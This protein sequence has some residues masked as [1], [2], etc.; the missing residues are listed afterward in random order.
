MLFSGDGRI[1][2]VA[3]TGTNGKTTTSRLL[4]HMARQSGCVT[5]LTTTDGIYID[6]ELVMTGD[7]SGPGSAQFVL[8]DP[9]VQFAVLETARGG[10][11]RSGLGFDQCD[12]AIVTNVAEDHLGL[13]GINSLID[14][15]KV[16][17]VVPESV[18]ATGYAILNADDDLVYAMKDRVHCK[19][20]LFS[21]YSDNVRIE[22][23]CNKGG[24][25]AVYE[26]GFLLLR[27]GNHIIPVEEAI[28]IPICFGGKAE[29]NVANV[30]AATLAAYTNQIRL[31]TIRQALR[32][33]I[34]S[35]DTTPGR[36]NMFSFGDFS[37]LLDY[38]HNPHGVRAL[39]KFLKTFKATHKVGI[40]TG[41]G[42]RRDEDIIAIGEESARIFDEIIIR[43]DADMRGRT[44]AEVEALLTEGIFKV[45]PS[46]RVTGNLA[47]CE[48]VE[49]AIEHA[50][51]GS[52]IV[53]LTDD[54]RS[55]TACISDYQQRER[56]G[57]WRKAG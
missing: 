17:S 34:P 42:D 22:A 35:A 45:R 44:V 11:L 43:H 2:V 48:S 4:A 47:E 31:S 51:A 24:L 5:G 30:L 7:C 52:L 13:D 38:A 29:F 40:I 39:G 37:V 57:V 46:L 49:Y 9:S 56:E 32:S 6:E 28:N 36:L 20:A 50:R 14:L 18:S 27:I 23:H 3:I 55:V 33:F 10:I 19:V 25:A 12:T 26:N 53:I 54:I 15:A 41:V 8:R 21:L 1:P 16:K